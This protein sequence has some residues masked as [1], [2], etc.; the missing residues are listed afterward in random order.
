[1]AEN[2]FP[3]QGAPVPRAGTERA[4]DPNVLQRAAAA[5]G[6]FLGL[7]AAAQRQIDAAGAAQVEAAAAAT[8]VAE[9]LPQRPVGLAMSAAPELIAQQ[10]EAWMGPGRPMTPMAPRED[11]AGRLFDYQTGYNL[12]TTPRRYEGIGFAQLRM[13]A[14]GCDLLRTAIETRKDQLSKIG[15][16]VLPK[17][18]ADETHRPKADDRCRQVEA[19]LKTPDG[20]NRWDVWIRDVAEQLFVCDA[21]PLYRRRDRGGKPFALEL[22]DPATI[23]V[24]ID[25]TGRRPL[26]PA[27]AYQQ[28]LKGIPAVNY[29]TE[30]LSYHKRNQRVHR[31]YGYSIV[32]QILVTVNIA[33]RRTTAQ[34]EHFTEGNI[35]E[36][37]A[38]A[39]PAWGP[40]QIQEFQRYFDQVMMAQ[41]AGNKRRMHFVP[42]GTGYI[43]TRADSALTDQFDE[44]LA[45]LICYA[46]SLPPFPFVRQQNRATAETAHDAALEEGIAPLL[47]YLKGILDG[48]IAG[49]FGFD[50]LEIVWDDVR[51][52]D[53]AE[54]QQMDL[55]DIRQGIISIDEVR[56][57]RGEPPLGVPHVIWGVGPLGFMSVESFKKALKMGLDMPPLPMSPEMGMPGAP[58]ADPLAGAPPE[59]LAQ[60]GIEG[61]P[62]GVPPGGPMMGHNGGPPMDAAAIEDEDL[63]AEE[64]EAEAAPQIIVPRRADRLR[65]ART[66]IP[67]ARALLRRMEGRIP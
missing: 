63:D 39:P 10:S 51:K 16:S 52:I 56:A 54:Q 4:L 11:V 6:R 49:F 53:P 35:P 20:V 33:L 62:E 12:S 9:V 46:F 58:G 23:N 64:E 3:P 8:N 15:F 67:E 44:W 27:P 5:V 47:V 31:V 40:Q 55:A 24:L 7:G 41:G 29:T 50:D 66:V 61:P 43:P 32:E 45:R 22:V 26:S 30:E 13:L 25:K 65:R 37:L 59:L 48:E 14:D 18:R 42:G 2:P 19:F 34:L 21:I 1:M 17:K 36:A 57:R 38:Q 28:I 60:L